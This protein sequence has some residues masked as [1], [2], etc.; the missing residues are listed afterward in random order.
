[1]ERSLQPFERFDLKDIA[2]QIGKK[3]ARIYEYD[4]K[5]FAEW[6]IEHGLTPADI[7]RSAMIGYRS[8]LANNKEISNATA[9]RMFS[10]AMRIAKEQLA[11][12]TIKLDPTIG[13]KGIKANDETT[14]MALDKDQAK[15]LLSVIDTSTKKGM[16]DLVI[17]TYLIR[18]ALRRSECAALKIGD[19]GK[20][21]GHTILF[22]TEAKGGQRQIVKM[23]VDVV[24]LTEEYQEKLG[25]YSKDA[26]LFPKF[27]KGDYPTQE[28]ISAKVIER[29]VKYYAGL[30]GIDDLTPHGLRA[31]FITLLLEEG[32]P[33]HKVQYAARHKDPRTTERYQKRKMN[34]DDSAVDKMTFLIR[35]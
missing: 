20:E 23:P 15:D 30:V 6:M 19:I 33:L 3:S 34:L 17:V 18:M 14:H 22:I 35:D 16:R 9:Q 2:G 32:V 26:P 11:N 10:I 8:Y 5:V 4:A 1:M 29:V 21:R 25:L 28:P 24:R 27:H 12:G 7:T 31:S 13:V